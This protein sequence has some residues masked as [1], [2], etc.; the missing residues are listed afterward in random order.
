LKI[1]DN[2]N[3]QELNDTATKIALAGHEIRPDASAM[4]HTIAAAHKAAVQRAGGYLQLQASICYRRWALAEDS[5]TIADELGIS[6]Q[7]VRQSLYRLRVIAQRLG[8]ETGPAGWCKGL[9]RAQVRARGP[10]V[11]TPRRAIDVRQIIALRAQG[12][13]YPE[14][15]ALTGF[16][17]CS[18]WRAMRRFRMEG[19]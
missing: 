15:T 18:L 8:Y 1:P 12:L 5:R 4:Q 2:L 11:R 7:H 17:K 10:R 3:W 13:T 19:I 9:T 16:A 14:I 6:R